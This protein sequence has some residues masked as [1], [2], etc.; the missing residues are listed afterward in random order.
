METYGGLF[1][2]DAILMKTDLSSPITGPVCVC[3]CIEDKD[4]TRF[5]Y[6]QNKERDNTVF[7]C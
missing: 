1:I 2:D 4:V 6:L 3:V 5:K 7:T